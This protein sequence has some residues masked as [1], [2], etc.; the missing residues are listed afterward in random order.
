MRVVRAAYVWLAA[1]FISW[2][3]LS[4]YADSVTLQPT[5]DTTLI[6]VAPDNN[7]GGADFFNAG[8][9]GVNGKRNRALMLFDLSGVIPIDAII[10]D[11]SLTLEVIRQPATELDNSLFSLRRVFQ[12]WAEG[13]QVPEGGPGLGAPAAL[14]EAT[15]NDRFASTVSWSQPG[16]LAGVDFSAAQSA[17]AASA[18]QGEQVVFESTPELISDVNLWLNQPGTNFGW[19][20]VTESEE[21]LKTARSFASHESGFGPMLTIQFTPVPEPATVTLSTVSAL[22][23]FFIYRRKLLPF[24]RLIATRR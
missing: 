5:A 22:I 4:L 11:V 8:T 16:G 18:G 23:F 2:H 10:T 6:E 15:W 19:M 9:A 7:L 20:L 17:L 24:L 1:T 14:G 3:G 21:I 12:S 13:T